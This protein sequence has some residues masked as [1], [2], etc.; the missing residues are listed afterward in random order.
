M[1]MMM[2]LVLMIIVMK[3]VVAEVGRPA[4][5]S[6]RVSRSDG[7]QVV[8]DEDVLQEEPPPAGGV[9]PGLQECSPSPHLLLL[10]LCLERQVLAGT[11]YQRQ[12]K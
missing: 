4:V 1:L 5:V 11:G 9:L 6:P 10:L 2:K 8:E 12:A 7:W 3:M